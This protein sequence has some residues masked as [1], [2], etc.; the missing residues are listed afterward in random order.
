MNN[1]QLSNIYNKFNTSD[2]T[3]NITP[4]IQLLL[5]IPPKNINIIKEPY[6]KLM[7]DVKYGLVHYFPHRTRLDYNNKNLYWKATPLLP[8]I[9]IDEIMNVINSEDFKKIIKKN[10][11]K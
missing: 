11:K 2:Q 9:N 7:T 5:V 1:N 6:R 8:I 10:S 4:E 3:N